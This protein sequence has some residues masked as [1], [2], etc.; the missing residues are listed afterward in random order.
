MYHPDPQIIRIIRIVNCNLFPIL[1]DLPFFRLIQSEKHTHQ[2][3]FS[4]PVFPQK[5]VDFTFFQ[6]QG[7]VIIRNDPRKSFRNVQHLYRI[8]R[9]F[10]VTSSP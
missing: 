6:L 10:P 1:A 3:G 9:H 7:N 8:F 5:G 4:R 2:C